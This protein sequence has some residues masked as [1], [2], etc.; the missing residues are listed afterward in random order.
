M[1]LTVESAGQP[2]DNLGC[3]R[4]LQDIQMVMVDKDS[5][6]TYFATLILYGCWGEMISC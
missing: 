1:L 6:T 4:L 5:R 2:E 3:P